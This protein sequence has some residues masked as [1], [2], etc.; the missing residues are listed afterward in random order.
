MF[1]FK[2]YMPISTINFGSIHKNETEDNE[3][4]NKNSKMAG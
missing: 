1:L 2:E 3:Q 4:H